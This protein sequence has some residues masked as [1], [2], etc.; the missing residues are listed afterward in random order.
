[1]AADDGQRLFRQRQ[2][3]ELGE[4]HAADAAPGQVLGYEPRLDPV[5]QQPQPGEMLRIE[6]ADAA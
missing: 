2:R 4:M 5:D 1:V 6:P 3:Q